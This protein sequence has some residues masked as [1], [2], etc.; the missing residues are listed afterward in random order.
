ME[1]STY[2]ALLTRV[3]RWNCI[4]LPLS[5]NL[6][7]LQHAMI[8]ARSGHPC[9]TWS[10]IKSLR[11]TSNF[12]I[13]TTA[14][15]LAFF[16]HQRIVARKESIFSKLR[17]SLSPFDFDQPHSDQLHSDYTSVTPAGVSQHNFSHVKQIITT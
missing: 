12:C 13:T 17:G 7:I 14:S 1:P 8:H 15:F 3:I 5:H 9:S 10:I 6:S 11:T 4:T 16:F 2:L